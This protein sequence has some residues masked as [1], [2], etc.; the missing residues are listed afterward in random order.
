MREEDQNL[1]S[2]DALSDEGRESPSA[3]NHNS[4][5]SPESASFEPNTIIK[6]GLITPH[7]NDMESAGTH[8]L[9]ESASQE[10]T[11]RPSSKAL[12]S[13]MTRENVVEGE[14]SVEPED[15]DVELEE[16]LDRLLIGSSRKKKE[17]AAVGNDGQAKIGAAKAKRQKRAEKQAALEAEGKGMT[18]SGKNR[19]PY[20]PSAAIQKA[21]GETTTTGK[22]LSKK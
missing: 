4:P 8:S 22:R 5:F 1:R 10:S 20:D 13:E 18:K 14:L 12:G 2:S 16:R 21:R 19:K 17:R 3:E 15:S 6:E 9:M 11:E 7:P